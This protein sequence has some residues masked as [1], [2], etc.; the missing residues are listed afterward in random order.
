MA[1]SGQQQQEESYVPVNDPSSSNYVNYQSTQSAASSVASSINT[2]TEMVNNEANR[3]SEKLAECEDDD[4]KER[5]VLRNS[6]SFRHGEQQSLLKE[7]NQREN[8][9]LNK[10]EAYE[11]TALPVRRGILLFLL[12]ALALSGL[13]VILAVFPAI[14][15]WF[16]GPPTQPI[17]PYDLVEIQVSFSF[18]HKNVNIQK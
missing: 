3:L 1:T 15:I 16:V 5:I 8:R 7:Y 14:R 2:E 4:A 11:G 9:Y 10:R 12:F 13:V 6:F 18:L 17:G